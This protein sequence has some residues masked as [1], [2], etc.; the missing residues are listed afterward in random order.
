MREHERNLR[1]E[2]GAPLVVVDPYRSPTAEQADIHLAPRPGTD[3]ALACAVMHVLFE[4]G[5]A[6]WDYLRRYTDTPDE[7][8]DHLRSRTPEWAQ[9]ITGLD[10]AEIV[11]F[12]RLY[13]RTKRSYHPLSMGSA[14]QKPGARPSQ[15]SR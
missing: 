14:P 13:G 2:R 8:R 1:E 6:D 10:P 9:R 15:R 11:A 12:A 4:E 3:G 7:L 5:L